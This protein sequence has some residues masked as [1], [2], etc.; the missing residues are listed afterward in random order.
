LTVPQSFYVRNQLEQILLVAQ[1]ERRTELVPLRILRSGTE[2]VVP[3]Y[4]LFTAGSVGLETHLPLA[5]SG[6]SAILKP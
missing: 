3:F 5:W 4:E 6:P 1:T 2:Q